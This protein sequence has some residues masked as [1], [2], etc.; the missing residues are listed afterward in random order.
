MGQSLRSTKRE[1]VYSCSWPAYLG[2]NETI[3]PYPDI[4]AAGCNLW[5]N[6][7]DI[8]CSW[9]SLLGVIDYW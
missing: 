6:W 1:I 5:R 3:K 7:R 4:I 8:Q 2:N 9:D